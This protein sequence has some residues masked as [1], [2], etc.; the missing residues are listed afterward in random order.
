MKLSP[1]LKYSFQNE[2]TDQVTENQCIVYNNSFNYPNTR[3]FQI[4][5]TVIMDILIKKLC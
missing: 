3:H 4:F 1:Q 2:V 5:F